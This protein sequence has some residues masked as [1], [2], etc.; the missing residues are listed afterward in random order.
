MRIFFGISLRDARCTTWHLT[1]AG[2]YRSNC[3]ELGTLAACL[4]EGLACYLGMNRGR[5]LWPCELN[6][7]WFAAVVRDVERSGLPLGRT[8]SLREPSVTKT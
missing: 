6:Y 5:W 1:S 8:P 2:Q 4:D 7:G 3:L